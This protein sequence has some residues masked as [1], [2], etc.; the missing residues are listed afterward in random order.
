V[1]LTL[2]LA[3]VLA[4]LALHP[5]GLTGERL[6]HLVYGDA[7]NQTTVRGEVRRL[8]ALIGPELLQT[9]PYR[10][11]PTAVSDVAQVQAAL[12]AGRAEAA[13]AACPGPLLPGSDAPAIRELRD[14]LGAGLRRAVLATGDLELLQAFTAHP[15]GRNDLEAHDRLVASLPVHDPRWR[16][17][18][19][20]RQ[21]LQAE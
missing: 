9:R 3:E 18:A 1:P 6:A 20:R 16:R 17:A 14:E 12:R 15:L 10:L 11:V 19:S 7:G 2:R 21:R 8:R 13:L 5:A 4:V